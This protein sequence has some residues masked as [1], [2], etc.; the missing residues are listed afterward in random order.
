[1][2]L[3]EQTGFED[4]DWLGLKGQTGRRATESVS[5]GKEQREQRSSGTPEWVLQGPSGGQ[6]VPEMWK[7]CETLERLAKASQKKAP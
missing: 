2:S 3:P 1:M 7:Q 4:R 6:A 5:G